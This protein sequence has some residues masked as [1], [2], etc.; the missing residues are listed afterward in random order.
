MNGSTENRTSGPSEKRSGHDV[1]L[2]WATAQRMLPLVRRIVEDI[3]GHLRDLAR[4]RPEK[5]R[6]DRNKRTLAWPERA[7]RYQLQEEIAAAERGLDS[8]LAE[9]DALGVSLI[10]ADAGQVGFP[11]MV[12]S[13]RA[14]FSWRPG[15]DG[16]KS[17]HFEGEDER[18]PIPSHW[19][20]PVEAR[21][22]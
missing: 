2:T 21:K 11:T 3:V 22:A 19:A 9:L 10:D 8:A 14:F 7:R 1:V 15:E 16:L 13:R 5:D 17:W 6:L 20:R 12:N 18:R 4:M